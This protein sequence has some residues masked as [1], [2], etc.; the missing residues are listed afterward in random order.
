MKKNILMATAVWFGLALAGSVACSGS[1]G[2][3]STPSSTSATLPCG[4]GTHQANG[5]CVANTGG[6]SANGGSG[7]GTSSAP[8]QAKPAT[9]AK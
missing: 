2:S 6:S 9:V 8:A 7:S 3:T 1:S 5:E 4:K